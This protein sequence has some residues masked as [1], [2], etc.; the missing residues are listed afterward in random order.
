M[1]QKL[2][3]C[4]LE[5]PDHRGK[6]FLLGFL[7]MN[8]DRGTSTIY[9]T[10]ST[11]AEI[12]ITAP[13]LNK[14]IKNFTTPGVSTRI[15]LPPGMRMRGL[16]RENKGVL[17]TAN[18]TVSVYATNARMNS[19]DVYV[20]FPTHTLGTEH[21][22][23]T[24]T[25]TIKSLIGIIALRDA[26]LIQ[27]KLRLQGNITYRGTVYKNGDI[28]RI[29]LNRLQTFQLQYTKDLTGTF[30]VST[31]PVVVLGGN[32]CAKVPVGKAG[33]SHLATQ[34]LPVSKWGARFITAPTAGRGKGDVFKI[35][36]GY[37]GTSIS[38][39]GKMAFVLNAGDFREFFLKSDEA[40]SINCSKP[41]MLMQ[42][43]KG[44]LGFI[45]S[46]PFA[47]MVPPI[48]QYATK[49]NLPI[50]V[51]NIRPAFTNYIS[52]IARTSDLES[53]A[54]NTSKYTKTNRTYIVPFSNYTV[55]AWELEWTL[56]VSTVIPI[57]HTSQG[58]R[59]ATFEVGHTDYDGY[60]YLGGMEMKDVN[61]RRL[62]PTGA[63][64][65]DMVDND[66]DGRIDEEVEDGKDD[67]GDGRIDE[68][69]GSI[70]SCTLNST[71]DQHYLPRSEY[72]IGSE[73]NSS[74]TG[75]N[76]EALITR[77]WSLREGNGPAV[78]IATQKITWTKPKPQ[79]IL[80]TQTNL[81]LSAL[82]KY[83]RTKSSLCP[84]DSLDFN[85]STS[86][87]ENGT[88]LVHRQWILQEKCGRITTAN[89]TI[90][91]RY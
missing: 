17:L 79:I 14:I 1:L 40:R 80:P 45:H 89:Q 4:S 51:K 61:C 37:N 29:F 91:G 70:T 56:S 25:P 27:I 83:V 18:T 52:I 74:I 57:S 41:V 36:A 50:P 30:L 5:S 6:S 42:Y 69:T 67:D 85:D 59:F 11:R 35:V 23:I 84:G 77:T 88:K 10:S 71:M 46:Q 32:I 48:E 34:L 60:G 47:M 68:D 54:F 75:Q 13:H 26:T 20:I 9:V 66:C 38:I 21:I 12:N 62:F 73:L 72:L 16:E 33:C 64:I 8:N 2:R 90:I 7:E 76:C 78:V 82:E 28:L 3:F 53:V 49:Y 63:T 31:G 87:M 43:N 19:R 15:D 44:P 55:Y 58:V 65:G 39:L 81:N 86:V 22:V 24:Y